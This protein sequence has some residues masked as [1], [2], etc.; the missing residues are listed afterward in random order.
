MM[1]SRINYGTIGNQDLQKGGFASVRRAPVRQAREFLARLKKQHMSPIFVARPF[2]LHASAKIA[3]KHAKYKRGEETFV[4]FKERCI[5]EYM[6]LKWLSRPASRAKAHV[7]KV[8]LAGFVGKHF[9][10]FMGVAPGKTVEEIRMERV[11][12][13]PRRL[14]LQDFHRILLA[15][16]TLMVE[17]VHHGD[18]N[19]G[20][21]FYDEPTGRV[22]FIDFGS[23]VLYGP[24]GQAKPPLPMLDAVSQ[25]RYQVSVNNMQRLRNLKTYNVHR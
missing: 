7:P 19:P 18:L 14:A 13:R 12:G 2:P 22:T 24:R 15:Y 3:I 10:M 20:N 21:I 4:G 11:N 25:S 17:G 5:N 8:Y 23:A 1:N 6:V 9:F 16:M